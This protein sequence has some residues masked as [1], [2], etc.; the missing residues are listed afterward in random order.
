MI[1][2]VDSWRLAEEIARIEPEMPVLIEVNVAREPQ[3]SG[4]DPAAAAD[5]IES[6]GRILSLEGLMAMGP[7]TGDPRPAFKELRRLRDDAQERL[8]KRLPILSM[9]MSGDF[10]AAVREGSTMVRLGQ[11]IFGP[12]PKEL[13]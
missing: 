3:K 2:T 11:A 13:A 4:V 12:R 8:A 5:L 6:V 9:G 10:E 7:S 1:Q